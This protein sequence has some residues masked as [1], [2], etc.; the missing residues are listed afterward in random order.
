M[1]PLRA[2]ATRD[3]SPENVNTVLIVGRNTRIG[4]DR[5]WSAKTKG[6]PLVDNEDANAPLNA[7]HRTSSRVDPRAT[8]PVAS[9]I[10]A[11]NTLKPK[12]ARKTSSGTR[13]NTSQPTGNPTSAADVNRRIRVRSAS[14]RPCQAWKELVS[15]PRMVEMTTASRVGTA[16]VIRGTESNAK[17][18]PTVTCV[19]EAT[20]TDSK[21]TT[22]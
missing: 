12:M 5:A 4:T 16:I 17:P 15:K 14:R 3:N 2:N 21:R 10:T 1:S 13:V 11:T 19:V 20:R 7:P 22:V 18:N 8:R 6:G 9:N